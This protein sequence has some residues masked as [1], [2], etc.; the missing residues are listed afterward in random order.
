VELFPADS[1]VRRLIA[2]V[3]ARN[4]SSASL[5]LDVRSRLYYEAHI[6]IEPQVG[7]TFAERLQECAESKGWRMSAF[8]MLQAHL[9][10]PK[11]FVSYRSEQLRDICEAVA[12][13]ARTLERCGFTVLRWKIEDTLFDSN[14]GDEL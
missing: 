9:D 3:E 12:D 1:V 6:T 10:P 5:P 13:M 11:A 14:R 2:K 7:E 4:I 8:L